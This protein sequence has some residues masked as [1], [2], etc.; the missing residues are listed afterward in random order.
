[1]TLPPS[2]TPKDLQADL[3]RAAQYLA[4]ADGLLIAAGAGMGVDSGLPD[5]RG[6]E[7]FWQAYP[8]LATAGLDFAEIATTRTFENDPALAWGFYGHRLQLYRDTVPH[9]GFDLLQL[10]AARIPHGAFVFTSNVDGQF[11]TAGF[12]ADRIVECHGSLHHLQCT[13][14]CSPDLWEAKDLRPVVN[15]ETCQW[16]TALPRCANCGRVA[17]PNILMFGDAN[18]VS[19][20]TELQEGRMR[21]WLYACKRPVVLE[22]GAGAH[23]PSVRNKGQ[24]VAGHPAGRL[25]RINPREFEV[26]RT[27]DVGLRMG[28]LAGLQALASRLPSRVPS[29]LP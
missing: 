8:A 16:G 13:K 19:D 24:S 20:R 9:A 23:L 12:A 22:L 15:D 21:R 10:L 28:A 3:D 25:I 27:E 11:Q 4:Q 2:D 17:R 29:R 26:I 6:T 18:W 1:M 7:G 5:F 14:P